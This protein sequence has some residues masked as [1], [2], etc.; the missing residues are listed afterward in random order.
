M[1]GC[2][3]AIPA[4]PTGGIAVAACLALSGGGAGGGGVVVIVEVGLGLGQAGDEAPDVAGRHDHAGSSLDL[5]GDLGGRCQ[6]GALGDDGPA[7]RGELDPHGGRNG[8]GQE[9]ADAS[10]R[11]LGRQAAHRVAVNPEGDGDLGVLRQISPREVGDGQIPAHLV[12][13]IEEADYHR[14]GEDPHLLAEATHHQ[15]GT[16]RDPL[17]RDLRQADSLPLALGVVSHKRNLYYWR[18]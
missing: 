7:L 8:G 4:G 2:G 18:I 11:Q 14:A 1:A 13:G 15:A 9:G 16:D 6:P 17:G 12:G 5:G 10:R 3:L